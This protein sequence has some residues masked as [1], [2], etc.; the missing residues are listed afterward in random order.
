VAHTRSCSA[1][2]QSD[3]RPAELCRQA[4]GRA[5]RQAGR[6]AGRRTRSKWGVAINVQHKEAPT[7][8]HMACAQHACR[9]P[10]QRIHGAPGSGAR[11]DSLCPLLVCTLTDSCRRCHAPLQDMMRSASSLSLCS[12]RDAAA[13]PCWAV[14]QWAV[15]QWDVQHGCTPARAAAAPP[16]G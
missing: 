7:M 1:G 3:H 11:F 9:A 10:V 8:K 16:G 4:C 14:Q 13:A 6:Q 15:Q 5:G 2:R 12:P